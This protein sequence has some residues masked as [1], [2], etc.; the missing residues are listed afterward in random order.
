MSEVVVLPDTPDTAAWM[1][2]GHYPVYMP[3]VEFWTPFSLRELFETGRASAWPRFTDK[4]LK[5][6]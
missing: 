3:D 5:N 4:F 2:K 1:A 6:C